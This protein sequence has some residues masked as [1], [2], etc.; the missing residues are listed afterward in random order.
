[1]NQ[2]WNFYGNGYSTQTKQANHKKKWQE[3]F[4]KKHG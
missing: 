2:N 1:M 4:T 3:A